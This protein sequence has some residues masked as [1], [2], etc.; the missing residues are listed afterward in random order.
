M[1]R[2]DYDRPGSRP[3]RVGVFIRGAYGKFLNAIGR[4]I[5]QEATDPVVG[6]VGAID[7]QFIVQAGA[8]TGGNGGNARLGGVRWLD[9]LGS[10]HKVSDVCKT[11]RRQRKRFEVVAADYASM[12]RARRI[13]RLRR[14]RGG[15]PLHIHRLT[16]A[17]QLER[18]SEITHHAD[19][20]IHVGRGVGKTFGGYRDSIRSGQQP[21]DAKFP[22][23]I[24]CGLAGKR[25]SVRLHHDAGARYSCRAC[26][27]HFSPQR[28]IRILRVQSTG[29]SERQ[30]DHDTRE[31]DSGTR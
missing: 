4:E 12:H 30:K 13:N 5:L 20:H 14:N 26:V 3:A 18:N 16:A 24:G 8:S 19:G 27:L 9:G 25:C 22:P 23:L 11:A 7:R 21:L 2:G 10:R 6:V 29:N 28:A 17:R 15:N 31:D 1:L